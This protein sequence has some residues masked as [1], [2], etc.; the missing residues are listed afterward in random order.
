MPPSTDKDMTVRRLVAAWDNYRGG[1]AAPGRY[2]TLKR[3]LYNVRNGDPFA[4]YPMTLID[5]DDEV[6]AA[7]EHYFLCRA[8]V[9]NGVQ[10][11]WQMRA[12]KTVYN[13][14]KELGVTPRHNPDKPVTPPSALQVAWQN[15]GIADGE[16]DLKASGGSAPLVA[17]PPMY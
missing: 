4:S 16:A 7:V 14:G 3:D 1:Q 5:P 13:V 6:M 17:A 2:L 8:W 15:R 11:A 12:M 9:G 10:P